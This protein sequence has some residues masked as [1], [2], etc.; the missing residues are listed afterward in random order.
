MQ[1]YNLVTYSIIKYAYL[2]S[3]KLAYLYVFSIISYTLKNIIKKK[4]THCITFFTDTI[5]KIAN[6]LK[7]LKKHIFNLFFQLF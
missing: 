5:N 3:T 7:N 4:L 6:I 1:L 2:L